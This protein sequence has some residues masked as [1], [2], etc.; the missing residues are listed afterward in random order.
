M[1]KPLDPALLRSVRSA[2]S[3]VLATAALVVAQTAALVVAALLLARALGRLVEGS[4]AWS[5]VAGEA[6]GV[7]VALAVRAALTTATEW[8]AHRGA[9]RVVAE[10]RDATLRHVAR[11]GPR[12]LEAH[13]AEVAT[14][15]TRGLDALEPYLV[16]YLPQLLQTAL[17]TPAILVVIAT[18]DL[19]SAATLAI[20]LPLIPVFMWLIGLATERTTRRR[21]AAQQRL[22]ARVL[23][24][25]A[26]LGTLRALGRARGT[27]ARVRELA[28]AERRGTMSTLRVAFLSGAALE[29]LATLSVAVVAVGVG[30][31]LV[32][33]EVGLVTGLAV[34]VLAP[35]VLAPLRHVGTHFHASADGVAA[36]ERCLEILREPVPVAGTADL[37]PVEEV[38]WDGV[39]VLPPGRTLP[40]PAGLHGRVRRGGITVL[41]G[42]SGAGKTS[43]ALALLGLLAPDA[44][45]VRLRVGDRR[46]D[47]RDVDLAAWHAQVAWVPQHPVLEPGTLREVALAGVDADD[48][49][50]RGAAER[51]G[52]AEVVAALPLGWDTPVGG[53]ARGLSAGQRQR[54]A[55]TRALLSPARFLVL[56]E[57]TA[58]LDSAS[59]A[60][61]LR[62]VT[63]AARDGVG[64]LV[65]THAPELVAAA[66]EVVTVA[67]GAAEPLAAE[68]LA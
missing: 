32:T 47:L 63:E 4:A 18:Q 21:L 58:H 33:G 17:L 37:G 3:T 27:V 23:D 57:P 8:R 13:R 67:A 1:A 66:D 45:V 35:E 56:D 30:L 9:T 68:V 25:V 24:L 54:L 59:S 5:E 34:L 14:L 28:D 62:L 53:R 50:L 52:F 26:G 39:D 22:D 44:G 31:R 40:T 46:L 20:T 2:R 60:Q 61:V 65:L 43:A 36:V 42:P 15:V 64:V 51:S 41:R 10:M 49:A 19:L 38:E 55:T 12:W 16:R 29:L 48:E 7:L 6:L 11:L